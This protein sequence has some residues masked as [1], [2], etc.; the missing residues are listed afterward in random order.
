MTTPPRPALAVAAALTAAL[1][2]TTSAAAAP[3]AENPPSPLALNWQQAAETDTSIPGVTRTTWTEKNLP[4]G[5]RPRLLQVVELDPTAAPIS[6]DGTV[7]KA[8]GQAETLAEQLAGVTTVV[9]RHPVAGVNGSLFKSEPKHPDHV[10]PV[11]AEPTTLQPM[12][13]SVT[14]GVLHSSSCWGGGTGTAGAVIQYGVPY[15]TTLLTTL[16]LTAADGAETR[17]DDINRDPGR[18][19]GCAR[20]NEDKLVPKEVTPEKGV[21]RDSDEIVLFT[22]DYRFPVP[23]PDLDPLITTEDDPG[24]EVVLDSTGK[25]TAAREGRGGEKATDQVEVPAGG[26]ILQGVGKGAVWLRTHAVKDTVL[27][28]GQKLTDTRLGREIV[29]DP[30]VDVVSSFHVLLRDSKIPTALPDTC[31]QTSTETGLCTDSRV[32]LG[33]NVR[34][35]TVFVTLTGQDQA[36]DVDTSTHEDGASLQ[37]FAKLVDSEELGLIEALNLDGGGSATL[38][39]GTTTHTPPTDRVGGKYVHRNVADSVYAGVSGY[40]MYAKPVPKP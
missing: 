12:G 26:R 6:L 20:D 31:G 1:A 27:T 15:I 5:T 37:T 28:V 14:D 32:A 36:D 16:N 3:A 33:T 29:L 19:R 24:F 13:V 9:A 10:T 21:F 34:G 35:H 23:K 18:A 40:G 30:S 38:M 11:G 2:L 17:F 7:G 8:A 4:A 25:V 39:T 22:D